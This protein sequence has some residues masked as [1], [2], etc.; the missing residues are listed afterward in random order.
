MKKLVNGIVEEFHVVY[1]KLESKPV[2]IQVQ[3][4]GIP[5]PRYEWFYRPYD[6]SETG[7]M[8]NFDWSIIQGSVHK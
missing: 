8:E 6:Q 1:A 2:A 3:A 5:S 4:A 7:D